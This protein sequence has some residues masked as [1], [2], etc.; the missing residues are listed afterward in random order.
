M[1]AYPKHIDSGK[2]IAINEIID[3]YVMPKHGNKNLFEDNSWINIIMDDVYDTF[4]RDKEEA[5]VAKAKKFLA[6][7]ESEKAKVKDYTKLVVTDGMVDYVLKKYRNKWKSQ[8]EITYVILEDLWLKY[9]NRIVER[10]KEEEHHHLKRIMER[11]RCMISKTELDLLRA[12]KAKQVDDHDDHDLDTLDLENRI[13]K[14]EEDF[15]RLL[16]EKKAKESKKAKKTRE[17][18]K[19]REAGL[20]KQVKKARKVELKAM[21]AKKV[22]EEELKA[23]KAKEAMLAKLKAKKAKKA[24]NAKEAMLAEVVQISSDE[25]DDEDPTA[26]TSTRSRA[27][28]TFTFTRSRASTASTSTRSEAPIA[29]TS[30]KKA[31]STASREYKKIDM[32]ECVIALFAPNALPPSAT[33]KKKST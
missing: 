2:V 8:D 6:M 13:K 33:R 23:K 12:I 16:K 10:E 27:P 31:A 17:A 32:T 19:A 7:V 5:K 29:S 21:E 25:D 28:T 18:K 26:L 15:G 1:K 20:A 9:G 3:G 24:K 11:E 4:Y 14:L 22:T 30:N